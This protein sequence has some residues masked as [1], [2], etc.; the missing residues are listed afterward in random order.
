MTAARNVPASVRQRLL[1][2]ARSEGRPFNELLQY[3]VMERVLYRLSSSRHGPRFVLK[4]ALLLRVWGAPVGR[5]TMDI[6]LLARTDNDVEAIERQVR[7]VLREPV[8]EDGLV[9]DV[10]S[11]EARR[12]VEAASYHGVRV[13]F[14]AHLA[15]AR[16]RLQIDI[17]FGD[18]VHPVAVEEEFPTLL[19][20]P[21]PRLLCYSRESAVAEKFEAMV[22]HGELN[23]RMKDF[24]DVWLLSRS[25]T[26][27]GPTLAEAIR[28]T[29]ASRETD[30]AGT[31]A[32]FSDSFALAKTSQWKAFRRRGDLEHAPDEFSAVI[33]SVVAFLGPVV[34]ALSR[35]DELPVAW[36]PPGPWQ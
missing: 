11:V 32:A 24:Y 1:D 10:E 12:I 25:F 23:S 16:V 7:E 27:D 30:V 4:G 19:S 35:G 33:R 22:R 8:E 21:A 34:T 31:I 26:F 17:G 3:Y 9:F 13:R 5:P 29:F 28:R 14:A 20:F 18:P 6:D 2:R 15:G 36:T